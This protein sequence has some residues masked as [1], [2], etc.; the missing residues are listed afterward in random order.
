MKRIYYSW[1][2]TVAIW[3]FSALHLRAQ[4]HITAYITQ[5]ER[6]STSYQIPNTQGLP[7]A[8]IVI[9]LNTTSKTLLLPSRLTPLAIHKAGRSEYN[10][11]FEPDSFESRSGRFPIIPS[12]EAMEPVELRPGEAMR[13][14][15]IFIRES[16]T[17]N[18]VPQ[19]VVKYRIT[20]FLANR[21][22]FSEVTS[23][24]IAISQR[25]YETTPLERRPP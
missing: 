24:T 12:R 5:A 16:V 17:T 21:F 19:I 6:L 20:P 10:F 9:V 25:E 11:T 15:P 13:L 7:S 2:L 14:S 22:G 18:S 1:S 8:L 4:V 3:I 23:T